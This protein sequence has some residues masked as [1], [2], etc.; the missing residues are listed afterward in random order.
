MCK[1][2][3]HVNIHLLRP[4]VYLHLH[5]CIFYM[6]VFL[7]MWTRSKYTHVCKCKFIKVKLAVRIKYFCVISKKYFNHSHFKT[8]TALRIN[9]HAHYIFT[10]ILIFIY[11]NAQIHP[12]FTVRYL[13]SIP[14]VQKACK[15]CVHTSVSGKKQSSSQTKG[16]MHGLV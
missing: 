4:G 13:K 11:N 2:T 1:Y 6:Y 14:F 7:V 9:F 3:P 8:N 12:N 15:T 5:I 10:K 16:F